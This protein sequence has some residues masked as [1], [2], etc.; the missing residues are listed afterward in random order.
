ML[1]LS[2]FMETGQLKNIFKLASKIH[3]SKQG[4][5]GFSLSTLQYMIIFFALHPEVQLMSGNN[6]FAPRTLG[7]AAPNDNILYCRC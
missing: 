5:L 1:G 3:P 6:I 4:K 7:W 2:W